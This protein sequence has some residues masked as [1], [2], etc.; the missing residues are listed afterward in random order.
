VV[1]NDYE[2]ESAFANHYWPPL[3]FADAEGVI[4]DYDLGQG[5]FRN[6]SVIQ[7]LHSGGSWLSWRGAHARSRVGDITGR[8]TE[9]TRCRRTPSP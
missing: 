5:R 2:V 1:D 8:L 7:R 4:R 6:S 3:Y 9:R